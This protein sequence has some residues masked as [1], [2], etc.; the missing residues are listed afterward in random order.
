LLS[1]ADIDGYL[2]KL[3]VDARQNLMMQVPRVM[4]EA[5]GRGEPDRAIAKLAARRMWN[6]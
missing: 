5:A 2:S 6:I 1:K 3:T 4:A